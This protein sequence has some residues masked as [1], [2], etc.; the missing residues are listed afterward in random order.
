MA[1]AAFPLAPARRAYRVPVFPFPFPFEGLRPRIFGSS[2]TSSSCFL[3]GSF[4][5]LLQLLSSKTSSSE[6]LQSCYRASSEQ[7]CGYGYSTRSPLCAEV[8]ARTF[9]GEDLSRRSGWLSLARAEGL[10]FLPFNC[11]HALARAAERAF[12]LRRSC[13]AHCWQLSGDAEL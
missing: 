11:F 13:V 1:D 7:Q 2:F 8:R 3:R 9:L 4:R 12:A 5:C 6:Q 10:I